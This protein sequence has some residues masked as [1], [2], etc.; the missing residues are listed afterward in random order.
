MVYARIISSA[1]TESSVQKRPVSIKKDVN[2]DIAKINITS[3]KQT[4]QFAYSIAV[5]VTEELSV[6]IRKPKA[7]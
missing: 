1:K 4:N 7:K 3:I 6:R 2:K 5:V